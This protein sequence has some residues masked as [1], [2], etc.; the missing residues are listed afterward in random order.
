MK[1]MVL[2]VLSTMM[3]AALMVLSTSSVTAFAAENLDISS[4]VFV[5]DAAPADNADGSI[6]FSEQKSMKCSFALPTVL[7]A[8]ESVTVNVKLQ[9]DSA[10]DAGVRFYL[11][12]GGVDVNT[13]VAI[14]SIANEGVGSIVE[15][16]FTLTAASASTELLFAS[17]SYGVYLNNVTIHEISI[18]EKEAEVP[19]APAA[20]ADLVALDLSNRVFLGG[21]APADNADGS[22]T[23]SGQATMKSSFALP[24]T[25]VAGD[26]INVNVKMKFDSEADAG[27]RF[28]LIANGID[29]NIATE[30]QAVAAENIGSVIEKS[31]VLTAASD[32][33][34]ILFASS[35]Y[36]VNIDNVTLYEI[37]L[38][39]KAVVETPAEDTTIEITGSEYVIQAG[40]TLGKIAAAA[41]L[42][43]KE[44][45][46]A[47]N[48]ADA[49]VIITGAKLVIPTVDTA[50]RYIVV[51]GDTL[52]K[53]AAANNCTV[54]DLASAN[55]IENADLIYVGQLIVLP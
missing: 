35:S 8:G 22:I 51:S 18:G 20:D 55:A 28:Y 3:I 47:N 17:A 46:E 10:D 21:A 36:G 11:I 7:N 9:F 23:F 29:S 43:V 41:G 40:D 2:R 5:S 19:E 42:T 32:S 26:S 54:A 44:I 31:F 12:S 49:D 48:I 33:T 39:E 4:R 53:I 16:T 13:A 1:K 45:A 38:G 15:K 37:T 25:L 50:K 34:E 52:S 6:T 30:I 27:V 24:E 14:E